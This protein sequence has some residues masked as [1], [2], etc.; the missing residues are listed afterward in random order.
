M[1]TITPYG[2]VRD[3]GKR[4]PVQNYRVW[5]ARVARR[6]CKVLGGK[7]CGTSWR[8]E[9]SGLREVAWTCSH[10]AAFNWAH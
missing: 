2:I 4:F 9:I 3:D 5:A 10:F 1:I 8:G 7:V 6:L